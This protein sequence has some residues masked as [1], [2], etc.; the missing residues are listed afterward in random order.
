[1]TV[2]SARSA[3]GRHDLDPDQVRARSRAGGALEH[4]RKEVTTDR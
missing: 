2:G 4:T 1:L 3:H